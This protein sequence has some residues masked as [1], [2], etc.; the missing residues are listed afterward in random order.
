MK[1]ISAVWAAPLLVVVA[2][3]LAMTWFKMRKQTAPHNPRPAM[4]ASIVEP[5]TPGHPRPAPSNA[6]RAPVAGSP[7]ELRAQQA[8]QAEEVKILVETG[9]DRL[10]GQYQSERVDNSWAAAKEQALVRLSTSPQIARLDAE[11]TSIVAHCRTSICHVEAEFASTMA[12]DDWATLYT[13]NI[14]VEMPSVSL[15]NE[16]RRD[17]TV[18]VK[19]YGLAR[20]SPGI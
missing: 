20:S 4:P 17:G 16:P 3:L 9:R 5:A 12:A 10:V 6:H 19:L 13:L 14:G 18:S 1:P 7:V 15:Q 11:P 8:L 2:I